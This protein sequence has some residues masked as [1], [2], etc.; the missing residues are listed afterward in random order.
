[1]FSVLQDL[2]PTKE[3]F[4]GHYYLVVLNLMAQRFEVMDS[5]RG[6]G[7]PSLA[8]DSATLINAIK[9]MWMLNYNNRSKI[10]ISGFQ[11]HFIATPMQRTM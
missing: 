6:V 2:T 7:T 8:S 3:E 9:H 10:D 5:M 1:M 11:T 4:T